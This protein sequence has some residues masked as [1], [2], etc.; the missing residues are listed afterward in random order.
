M[1]RC[2]HSNGKVYQTLQLLH[3]HSSRMLF[4]PWGCFLIANGLQ[5]HLTGDRISIQ[6]RSYTEDKGVLRVK[7]DREGLKRWRHRQAFRQT[8]DLQGLEEVQP[9]TRSMLHWR[10]SDR[11]S[12]WKQ[13]L[14]S[15]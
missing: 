15:T 2:C 3:Q 7:N 14:I 9:L 5:L 12:H 10:G 8:S 6:D 4:Q 11:E 13:N 1:I